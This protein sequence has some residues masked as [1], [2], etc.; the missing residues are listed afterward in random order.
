MDASQGRLV[1]ITGATGFLGGHLA[2]AFLRHGW[3]VRAV[4]RRPGTAGFL[5]GW[6]AEAVRA[7]LLDRPALVEA[8]AGCDVVVSNAA[9]Y[10]LERAAWDDF[11]RPNLTGTDNVLHAAAEAGVGRVVQISSTAV[12][13]HRLGRLIGEGDRELGPADRGRQRHYAVTKALS[14]RM[15]VSL[16]DELDLPLVRLRP[17]AIYGSRDRQ[18]GPLLDRWLR[19]VPVVVVPDV[20]FPM[21]HAADVAEAAVV[22]ATSEVSVGRAYN[23][24]APPRP[25]SQVLGA[26]RD[27]RGWSR[28]WILRLP[29]PT[30]IA[31]D[32]TAARRD[33]GF[34]PRPLEQGVAEAM[35][36]STSGPE[37]AT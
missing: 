29:L 18:F 13:K 1:G 24:A 34:N 35:Q 16:A 14:D 28:P 31:Y 2:R 32:T 37:D 36:A 22:A 19:R 10:T 12:Y 21:V 23:L 20:G 15:A 33:L 11:A 6:G 8:F 3:R 5:R 4:V 30:G 9:L 26:W 17:C 27:A 7:D 25:L